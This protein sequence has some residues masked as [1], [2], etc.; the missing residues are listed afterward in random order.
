MLAMTRSWSV[1]LAPVVWGGEAVTSDSQ[2]SRPPRVVLLGEPAIVPATGPVLKLEAHDAAL[3]AL[4]ALQGVH[5]RDEMAQL[6]WPE[7]PRAKALANLR[8]RL[9]R[10]RRA[11][12]HRLVS[13]GSALALDED[14][15]HD[16]DVDAG[17]DG[18]R[19][20]ELLGSTLP[21]LGDELDERLRGLRERWREARSEAL[22]RQ[23]AAAE[24]AGQHT[25]ALRL[26]TRLLLAQPTS[27]RAARRCMRLHYLL[28]DRAQALAVHAALAERLR[29]SV[30]VAPDA[31]TERL[32]RLI[33]SAALTGRQ[34]LG[35]AAALAL[36][37]PPAT[38]GREA[39][40]A[41]LGAALAQRMTV[42]ME[43]EP[44]IGKTRLLTDLAQAHPKAVLVRA[45]EGLQ[46][47][48]FALVR[49]WLRAGRAAGALHVDG[50]TESA[51]A[52][53]AP[54]EWG[55]KATAP[56]ASAANGALAPP[57]VAR[58]L[59]A[60]MGVWAA[61]PGAC[62][63]IDDVQWS[64]LASQE[65]LIEW[66]Q[67]TAQPVAP[68]ALPS[69]QQTPV[70]P[71]TSPR[72]R[73]PL[74]LAA[75]SGT[76]PAALLQAL[77]GHPTLT[78]S[79]PPLD[80]PGML[81]LLHSLR[82]DES[83]VEAAPDLQAAAQRL[84]RRSGGHPH[85]TLE[86]LRSEQEAPA[87]ERA[88]A[89]TEGPTPADE[90]LR[91]LLQ[92]R[93]AHLPAPVQ[94][95]LHV[96]AVAG[97]A[98]SV[99]TAHELSGL[100]ARE[101]PALQQALRQLQLLD[102]DGR[103][104]DVVAD[105]VE[106]S[107]PP[108]LARQLHRALAERMQA[109]ARPAA[110][111]A[112]HWWKARCWPEAAATCTEAARAA[113]AGGRAV[114]ALQQWDRAALAHAEAGDSAAQWQ[115]AAAAL[116][117]AQLVEDSPTLLA[118]LD[119]MALL[120]ATE[121]QRLL[122]LLARS[123]A[124]LN[125]SDAGA[126]QRVSEEALALARALSDAAAEASAVGWAGLALAMAGQLERA[127][128]MLRAFEP[129][130]EAVADERARLDF[131]GAL[132]Y[133]LHVAGDYRAAVAAL[134][135]ALALAEA[136][137]D[138]AEAM[139]QTVNLAIGLN[140]LG[141]SRTAFEAGERAT[142]L[143]RRLGEP[144][145]TTAIA[146]RIQQA[147][148]YLGVGRFAEGLEGLEWALASLRRSGASAW[149]TMAEHRLAAAY[150]RLGQPA[151][152]LATLSALADDDAGRRATRAIIE[153]RAADLL[154]R[155]ARVSLD[156]LLAE[157]GDRLAPMDAHSLRL[158]MASRSGPERARD[159]ALEVYRAA[160]AAADLPA[161]THAAARVADACAQLGQHGEAG[162]WA[163]LAWGADGEA[164]ALDIDRAAFCLLVHRGARAG[165]D[166]ELARA[167]LRAG[168]AW[169]EQAL[170]QVPPA[171]EASCRFRNPVY[172]ELL[173]V[174][175]E[176]HRALVPGQ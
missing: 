18:V 75:R 77:G 76:V 103:V 41:Q 68:D 151:R 167:A 132:G 11:S 84:L 150:L 9:F 56:T 169:V 155:P 100:D 107:L 116:G 1:R 152:A 69:D 122:L 138:L 66:L 38:V 98:I 28:G 159:L 7:V 32:A 35:E 139:E 46:S 95:L 99:A 105:A 165:G 130:A 47:E 23:A 121:P 49:A 3:F 12:G 160:T 70:P 78:L 93:I 137:G 62:L 134:R 80:L 31:E 175:A 20:L 74:V 126:A 123:R 120:A 127:V 50:A 33:H 2:K 24:Q 88:N 148:L 5:A 133:A 43:G 83:D 42:W 97:A 128:S 85:I 106:C 154:E 156:E 96:M 22:D 136:V 6:L 54:A 92:R 108:A 176:S 59:A 170:A 117:V 79:L 135:R 63:L 36:A 142:D 37:R 8:Q 163:R 48:P 4:L 72:V 145:S 131:F 174:P 102:E 125:A 147:A 19:E 71:A 149:R 86:L 113:H 157:L 101:L 115:S 67:L 14:I 27:E 164:A 112:W 111:V 30:G 26:A 58:A 13:D 104:F 173:S 44:G 140:S 144:R 119:A 53:V 51:L 141:E 166:S 64:D 21:V 29:Q 40:W 82:A 94:Q 110:L 45:A 52:A 91:A 60:A 90:R 39:V 168:R 129:T 61:R 172:R 81:A 161:R 109:D 25:Q 158:E 15:E 143:W 146:H 87:A 153:C 162:R 73:P 57:P 17:H 10:L 171:F 114:E 118:R 34:P 16:L 55:W 124:V 65:V 89:A